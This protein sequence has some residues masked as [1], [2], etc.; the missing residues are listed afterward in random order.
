MF[1]QV[2]NLYDRYLI[3][4]GRKSFYVETTPH[5]TVL[6]PTSLHLILIWMVKYGFE[7]PSFKEVQ[8]RQFFQKYRDISKEISKEMIYLSISG[9]K[10]KL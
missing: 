9:P 3:I 2:L 7:C 10:C 6:T 5:L 1:N 4:Q 8:L